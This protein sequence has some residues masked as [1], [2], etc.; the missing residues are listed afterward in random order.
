MVKAGLTGATCGMALLGVPVIMG[1]VMG[2][3]LISDAQIESLL[4]YFF[5]AGGAAAALAQAVS[6]WM[7]R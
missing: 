1:I 4:N 6:C 2:E 7:S 3:Q 5:I